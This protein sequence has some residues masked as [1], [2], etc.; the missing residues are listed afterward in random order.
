MANPNMGPLPE[1]GITEAFQSLYVKPARVGD[2]TGRQELPTNLPTIRSLEIESHHALSTSPQNIDPYDSPI[3]RLPS[4]LLREIISLLSDIDLITTTHVCHH[5]RVVLLSAPTLWSHIDFSQLEKSK[6]YL[7]RACNAP[8]HITLN[9]KLDETILGLL[10]DRI[11]QIVSMDCS[12]YTLEPDWT[13]HSMPSMKELNVTGYGEFF[14]T[15]VMENLERRVEMFP[16]LTSLGIM[17]TIDGLRLRIPHLTH[18]RFSFHEVHYWNSKGG[19]HLLVDFFRSCP[20]LEV[21]N[22]EYLDMPDELPQ[23][24][25]SYVVHLPHL[26]SFTQTHE[27]DD[28]AYP[29]ELL[30]QLSFPPTCSVILKLFLFGCKADDMRIHSLFPAPHFRETNFTDVQRIKIKVSDDSPTEGYQFRFVIELINTRGT[31]FSLDMLYSYEVRL[32]SLGEPV[33]ISDMKPILREWV[34]EIGRRGSVE[35]LCLEDREDLGDFVNPTA[36]S[37]INTLILSDVAIPSWFLPSSMR[38]WDDRQRPGAVRTF[39]F[40]SRWLWPQ[41]MNAVEILTQLARH[42]KMKG[43]PFEVLH[44]TFANSWWSLP[45]ELGMISKCVGRLD[46]LTGDNALDWKADKYFLSGLE[47]RQWFWTTP[48][49]M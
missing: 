3:Y 49:Y 32:E 31:R 42:Q 27:M 13:I 30:D 36:I 25:G 34:E 9:V 23:V 33:Y 19:I 48:E 17:E 11:A 40:H 15:G 44:S 45:G 6:I 2:D 1:H 41:N 38:P 47:H 24:Y 26:R 46:I 7:E 28:T 29:A 43:C 14:G 22:V 21:I 12:I 20:M 18:F 39:I 4:E 10:R 37:K 16:Y 8:I 35:T 5:W